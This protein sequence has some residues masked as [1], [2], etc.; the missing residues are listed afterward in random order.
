MRTT[1]TLEDDVAR[2][3]EKLQ[4]ERQQ[5]FKQIVNEVLRAGLV[6]MKPDKQRQAR[7]STPELSP[8]TCKYPNLDNVAEVLAVAERE[9]FS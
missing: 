5:P 9:D 8:G 2:M 6:A 1:L 4:K 3:L 7:Y